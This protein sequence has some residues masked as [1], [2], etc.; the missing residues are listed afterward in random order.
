M[1]NGDDKTLVRF[2]AAVN[3]FRSRHKKWPS[4]VVLEPVYIA[5]LRHIL[6]KADFAKVST[7]VQL[8]PKMDVHI[9]AEGDGGE[10]YEY[11]VEG[12]AKKEP[13]IDAYK[14]F[15]LE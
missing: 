14:W 1:P 2:C 12:F 13:D 9:R 6:S 5:D 11:S 10:S 7:M 3:G 4:R 8:M 15:G